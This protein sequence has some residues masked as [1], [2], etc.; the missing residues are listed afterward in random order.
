VTYTLDTAQS[1]SNGLA[2]L[3]VNQLVEPILYKFHGSHDIDGSCA[4]SADQCFDFAW[5]L[6]KQE[7]VPSQISRII[8][9]STLVALGSSVLDHDFRLTYHTLLRHALDSNGSP[10]FAIASREEVDRRDPNL[11]LTAREWRA[12]EETAL[13]KYGIKCI[14]APVADFLAQLAA[15]LRAAWGAGA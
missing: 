14:D 1:G 11:Q 5:R 7:C 10:R 8:S 9:T 12:I 2:G 15:R 6:L 3:A 4:I 13:R